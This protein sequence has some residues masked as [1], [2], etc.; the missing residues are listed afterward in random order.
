MSMPEPPQRRATASDSLV[1]SP[2]RRHCC[3]DANDICLGCFRTVDEIAAWSRSSDSARRRILAR[4]EQR[5][6]QPGDI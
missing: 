4:A 3:L 2:C 1:P 5:K 6:R